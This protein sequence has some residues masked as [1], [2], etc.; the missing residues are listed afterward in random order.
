MVDGD[1]V[2][3]HLCGHWFRSVLAHL[4]SHGWSQQ[5]Y[6]QTFGLERRA[7]L[8]GLAIRGQRAL[9]FRH[10]RVREAAVRDGCREGSAG[11]GPEPWRK[12][13]RRRLVA[14][15]SPS[16]AAALP[17]VAERKKL[18]FQVRPCCEW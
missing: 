11:C 13:P 18:R 7:S 10:R 5:L 17:T 6:R 2:Q 16:S 14:G 15:R 1:V 4:P 9:A 3:C 12:R 8:E